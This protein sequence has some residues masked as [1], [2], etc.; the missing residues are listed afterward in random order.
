MLGACGDAEDDG[1]DAGITVEDAFC[2]DRLRIRKIDPLN[3]GAANWEVER[4]TVRTCWRFTV[5]DDRLELFERLPSTIDGTPDGYCR[6]EGVK[7][8]NFQAETTGG[9]CVWYEELGGAVTQTRMYVVPGGGIQIGGPDTVSMA[10]DLDTTSLAGDHLLEGRAGLF[11]D[12]ARDETPSV[13]P[14]GD[15]GLVSDV[16]GCDLA[17]CWT[18]LLYEVFSEGCAVNDSPVGPLTYTVSED[19]REIVPADDAPLIAAP[20]LE[21]CAAVVNIGSLLY[22][23]WRLR[24]ER[25]GDGVRVT[26][27][28]TAEMDECVRTLEGTWARCE[29]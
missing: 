17:G 21:R 11:Y 23:Q 28:R 7:I 19:R 15:D 5:D 13:D 25:D 12:G 26:A 14:G 4:A 2:G 1:G 20:D 8:S 10:M 24:F 9:A 16:A 27:H 22:D 18:G 29:P 3:E 6:I